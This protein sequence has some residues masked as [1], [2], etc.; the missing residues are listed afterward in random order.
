LPDEVTPPSRPAE[1]S[2]SHSELIERDQREDQSDAKEG[3]PEQYFN[4]QIVAVGQQKNSHIRSIH[5]SIDGGGED[6]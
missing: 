2:F 1:I 6:G 3:G 4:E 5:E